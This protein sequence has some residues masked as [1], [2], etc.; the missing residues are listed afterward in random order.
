M[1]K[2]KVSDSSFTKFSLIQVTFF[3][4]TLN[5]NW[6]THLPWFPLICAFPLI[7]L[8]AFLFLKEQKKPSIHSETK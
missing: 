1:T 4:D 2:E 7:E 5:E 8:S 3:H 6:P